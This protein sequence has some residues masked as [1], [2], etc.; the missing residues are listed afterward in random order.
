[1][2][3]QLRAATIEDMD[4]L[5][6]WANDPLVRNN[7]FSSEQI[8]YE[9]HKE[10]YTNL[11][12]RKDRKQYIYEYENEPVGQIR[13]SIDG[14]TAEI[15]YS[16]CASK[17]GMGHGKNM[18]QLLYNQVLV[19]FPEVKKLVGK[20]KVDNVAS[21]KAFLDM[22]YQENYRVFEMQMDTVKE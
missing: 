22:G 2:I 17:R 11:M 10:W 18:L 6:E 16:I 13:L 19:D 7:S 4:I 12:E 9:E 5:F 1:M 20:V 14:D 15:G 3:G 8:L 21:Q